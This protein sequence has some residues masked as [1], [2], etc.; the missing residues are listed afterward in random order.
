MQVET[1]LYQRLGSPFIKIEGEVL[2]NIQDP[3]GKHTSIPVVP[4][5]T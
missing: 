3:E 1:W 2:T 4:R 5:L